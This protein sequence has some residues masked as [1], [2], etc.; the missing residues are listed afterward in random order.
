MSSNKRAKR[1]RRKR[2]RKKT[3]RNRSKNGDTREVGQG[4]YCVLTVE[5]DDGSTVVHRFDNQKEAEAQLRRNAR[6]D[7]PLVGSGN[8]EH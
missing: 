1:R 4:E 8:G 5:R 3:K 7:K 6:Q 2:R